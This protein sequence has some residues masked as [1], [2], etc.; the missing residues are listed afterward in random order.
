MAFSK[1]KDTWLI[2]V[3]LVLAAGFAIMAFSGKKPAEQPAPVDTVAQEAPANV[4][5]A[6]VPATGIKP[7]HSPAD[8]QEI[9]G[10]KPA[11]SVVVPPQSVQ[12]ADRFAVQVYSF[13]DKARAET[14]LKNLKGKNYKAYIMVSDLGPRGIWYR[15]RVGAFATEDAARKELESITKEF[16]SGIIV[17]E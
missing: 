5:A 3:L 6:M 4:P 9:A 16:K 15:V 7:D 12:A 8:M 13:K 1:L 10:N 11:E 17:S 2:V 14:A